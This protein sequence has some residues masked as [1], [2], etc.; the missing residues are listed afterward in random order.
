VSAT[1]AGGALAASIVLR[2]GQ[3]LEGTEVR[4]DGDLVL[5]IMASGDTLSLP[6]GLV[7]DIR[8]GNEGQPQER[9]PEE[10]PNVPPSGMRYAE[11]QVLAGIEVRPP[12]TAEQLAVFGEPSR[13]QPGVVDPNWHPESAFDAQDDVMAGSRSTF[14]KSIIDSTWHPT[15]GFKKKNMSFGGEPSG[16]GMLLGS[17]APPPLDPTR[18]A[19]RLPL[20]APG[21][22][23]APRVARLE[24]ATLAALPFPVYEA[25][26]HPGQEPHRL[27]FA[28]AGNT[29]RYLG[30][31]VEALAGANVG[32]ELAA[33]LA[34]NALGAALQATP[35]PGGDALELAF[36]AA[37]LADPDFAGPARDELRLVRTAEELAAV[38]VRERGGCKHARRRHLKHA[39]DSFAAPAVERTAA[40]S[41]ARFLTW[42]AAQGTLVRHEVLLSPDGRVA[43]DRTEI[44]SHLGPHRDRPPEELTR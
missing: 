24:A 22:D 4:R 40:G 14:Q 10:R 39:R 35:R 41:I 12:T 33:G 44:A 23:A 17:A 34:A 38:A 2:D 32:R 5:L 37:A 3:V 42:S 36:A 43:L 13:F 31:D 18:C 26:T 30:G 28:V 7:S 25:E 15:D 6:M 9:E 29:C 21:G 19:E 20:P 8:L 11:P 27:L 1:A 16:L